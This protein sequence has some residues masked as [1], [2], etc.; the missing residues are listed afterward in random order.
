MSLTA[1]GAAVAALVVLKSLL[2]QKK[3]LTGKVV[4]ITGASSGIGEG[5]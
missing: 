5:K 3:Q 2:R 1:A 4:V